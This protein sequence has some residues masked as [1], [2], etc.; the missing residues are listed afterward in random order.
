MRRILVLTSI[1]PGDDV[2]RNFTPVV[3]YFTREWIKMGYEVRVI[4]YV[5][6]FPKAFYFFSR[7]SSSFLASK[8]GFPIRTNEL[9]EREYELDDVSVLR[10]SM[11]KIVP[12][13]PH[14]KS[15]LIRAEK[16]TISYLEAKN[17]MPDV[18]VSHWF[19]P[20]V[21]IM[22]RLKEHFK[23]PSCYVCHS[24]NP[25]RFFN[26]DTAKQ[27]MGDC[28]LIGYRSEHIKKCI[29][30][31][32]GLSTPSF[33]CYSGIPKSFIKDYPQRSFGVVQRY[34][35]V[36]NLIKRKYPSRI[37]ESLAESYKD[38][39][40]EMRFIGTGEELTEMKN[41]AKEFNV[42][43]RVLFMGRLSREN[44][45]KQMEDSDVFIMISRGETYGLVYLEAMARGCITIASKNEGFDGIIKDGV[46]GFLCKAGDS[47][48]LSRIINHIRS[49]TPEERRVISR[50]AY[51]TAVSMTDD[52]MANAYLTKLNEIVD[53]SFSLDK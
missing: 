41:K 38:A 44:V 34:I 1:Y 18:I 24:T 12:H 52:K 51:E 26:E 6:N 11:K 8:L 23:V 39:Y 46:N 25:A 35:F 43:D 28:D 42:F 45:I 36:G 33:L 17:F 20:Q 2:P 53:N 30:S 40:F 5:T 13:R 48:D 29:E 14:S 4:N 9:R 49:L 3:H 50:N 37:I 27:Q 19:N 21:E 16:K 31:L 47:E 15:Q 22:S 7:F 10:I 32:Y